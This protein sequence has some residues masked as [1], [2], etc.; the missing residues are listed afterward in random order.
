MT[1]MC[2]NTKPRTHTHTQAQTHTVVS[3]IDLAQPSPSNEQYPYATAHISQSNNGHDLRRC[4]HTNTH[5]F[6]P[7]GAL[8]GASWQDGFA[9]LIKLLIDTIK[10]AL[11]VAAQRRYCVIIC[12]YICLPV[13]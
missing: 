13:W 7:M 2:A 10:F 4:Q 12:V 3:I 5:Q 11:D 6:G 9:D 1:D 8:G